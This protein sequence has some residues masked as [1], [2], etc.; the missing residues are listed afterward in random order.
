[1]LKQIWIPFFN[2][3]FLIQRGKRVKCVIKKLEK[4]QETFKNSLYTCFKCERNN[5]FSAEKQLRS[6]N[7]GTS[8]NI[9]IVTINGGMDGNVK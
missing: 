8:G 7:G 2:I 1:M 4:P 9:V 6:A 5:V 3:L